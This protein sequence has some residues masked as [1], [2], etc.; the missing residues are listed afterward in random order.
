MA[1]T[2]YAELMQHLNTLSNWKPCKRKLS[3]I[4]CC[5]PPVGTTG[6]HANFWAIASVLA[7]GISRVATC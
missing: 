1:I 2:N 6:L 4:W 3:T 7:A 5:R